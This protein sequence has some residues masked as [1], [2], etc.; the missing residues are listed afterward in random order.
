ML[1]RAI[2]SVLNQ[3]YPHLRV[4]VFDNASGDGTAAVVA[5]LARGD[6]RVVYFCHTENVGMS[7]NFAYAMEQVDTPYF[8]ML[9]DDDYYY[10]T[11]YETAMEGF[12][13]YPDV[14]FS[15]AATVM[16]HDNG[17]VQV[18]SPAEGYFAPPDGFL[19]WTQV[20]GPAITGMVFR[21]EIIE[22]VGVIDQTIFHAD[23]E[24]SWRIASRYPF[25]TSTRPGLIF[26]VHAQQGTRQTA[27]E[28]SLQSY[29]MLRERMRATPG[30]PLYMW[31]EIEKFLRGRFSRPILYASLTAISEGDYQRGQQAAT[32]LRTIFGQKARS[33]SLD[34]LVQGCT[35]VPPI[36]WPVRALIWAALR[37]GIA[38][39]RSEWRKRSDTALR[40]ELT[41]FV[42][43]M[44]ASSSPSEDHCRRA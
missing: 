14:M 30:I 29:S 7:A 2:R 31:D 32:M 18:G 6:A 40:G 5:E 33:T 24:Y 34:I 12:A 27:M 4:C 16:T 37:I 26:N 21:R 36:R 28:T 13:R 25:V 20:R 3:T 9:S 19:I 1:R 44:T 42:R 23:I 41:E 11:F 10:P 39:Y 15:A 38:I 8:S 35:R 17:S 43:T 22:R